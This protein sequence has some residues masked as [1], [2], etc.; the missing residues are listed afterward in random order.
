MQISFEPLIIKVVQHNAVFIP[1]DSGLWISLG[2]AVDQNG[3]S[4]NGLG[5]VLRKHSKLR[6]NCKQQFN[7]NKVM[8]L[9]NELQVTLRYNNRAPILTMYINRNSCINSPLR[10]VGHT[11]ISSLIR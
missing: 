7:L 10:I 8:D 11:C 9:K 4:F 6:G 1:L 2:R 5:R 3:V